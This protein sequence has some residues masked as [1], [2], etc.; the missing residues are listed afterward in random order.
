MNGHLLSASDDHVCVCCY[1]NW[2][3]FVNY[4]TEG[5]DIVD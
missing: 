3:C 1:S 4:G 2:L 5:K